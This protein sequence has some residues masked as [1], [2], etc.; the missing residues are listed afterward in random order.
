MAEINLHQVRIFL[1]VVRLGSITRAAESLYM[2]Q[3]AVTAQL[4]HLRAFAGQP[5]LM[6]DGRR[7]VPTPAGQ[8][9]YDYASKVLQATQVVQRNLADIASGES[10]HLVVAA[11]HIYGASALPNILADL[12]RSHPTWTVSLVEGTS[13]QVIEQVRGE[14]AD[15]GIVVANRIPEPLRSLEAGEDHLVVIES[16]TRP[17]TNARSLTFEQ[18]SQMPFVATVPVGGSG[19]AGTQFDRRLVSMNLSPRRVLMELPSWEAFKAAVRSGIGIGLAWWSIVCRE[20]S[21][22]QLRVLEVPGYQETLHAKLIWLGDQLTAN[23]RSSM[24]MGAIAAIQRDLSQL[25]NEVATATANEPPN[26]DSAARG[27]R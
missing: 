17:L 8:A 20:V 22:G 15:A 25:L 7:L 16:S 26:S 2:T 12:C 5:L 1:T 13:D 19:A 21:D 11:N 4:R 14:E 24:L 3:P 27:L 6:R 9:M 18:L 23:P 10:G